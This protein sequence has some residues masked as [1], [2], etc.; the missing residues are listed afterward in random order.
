MVPLASWRRLPLFPQ[1]DGVLPPPPHPCS[2]LQLLDRESDRAVSGC[3]DTL[4]E[5]EVLRRS[6]HPAVA[7]FAAGTIKLVPLAPSQAPRDMLFQYD[8]SKAL[9]F[10]P[11]MKPPPLD[12]ARRR[13]YL[14]QLREK[15]GSAGPR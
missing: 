9:A 15:A 4:F 8:A 10:N 12:G 13:A 11:P 2:P 5:L 14:K 1:S 7:D 3:A 6:Y